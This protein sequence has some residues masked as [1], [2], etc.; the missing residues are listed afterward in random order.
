M[1]QILVKVM[2][3]FYEYLLLIPLLL[4][5]KIKKKLKIKYY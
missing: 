4:V 5:K 1:Q 3:T 2:R